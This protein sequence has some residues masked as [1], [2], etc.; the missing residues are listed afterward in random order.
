MGQ[1]V[2]PTWT[3]NTVVARWLE[4]TTTEKVV[5]KIG[6]SAEDLVMELGYARRS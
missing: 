2:M 6:T 3:L 4:S 1:A 5:V